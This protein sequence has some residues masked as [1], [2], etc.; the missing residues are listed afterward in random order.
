MN[1]F[2]VFSVIFLATG[3][4][5]KCVPSPTTV[6]GPFAPKG[7]ICKGKLLFNENFHSLNTDLWN[8]ELRLGGYVSE[9]FG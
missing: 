3:C 6:S 4:Q 7:R 5:S 9:R 8:H 1:V 2:F